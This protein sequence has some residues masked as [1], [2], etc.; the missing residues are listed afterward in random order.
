MLI[1]IILFSLSKTQS[2]VSV[3]TLSARDNQKLSELFSKGF[4]KSVYWNEYKT[5]VKIK[6]RQMIIDIFLNQILFESINCLF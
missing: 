5:K 2:Y 6:T 1:L 4:E 3:I